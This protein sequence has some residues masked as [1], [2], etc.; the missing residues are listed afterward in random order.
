M[1]DN[2]LF[3]TPVT[4]AKLPRIADTL[5][6]GIVMSGFAIEDKVT[7]ELPPASDP[8]VT[9]IPLTILYVF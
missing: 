1:F 5:A 6:E 4:N 8:V 2:I 3:Q 7:F 9:E